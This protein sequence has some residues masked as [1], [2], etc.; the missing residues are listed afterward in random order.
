MGGG[1]KCQ[2]G[3]ILIL[4]SCQDTVLEN[5]VDPP[6][7]GVQL[8]GVE[9]GNVQTHI[10]VQNNKHVQQDQ[11]NV[12]NKSTIQNEVQQTTDV[13]LQNEVQ[14]MTDVQLQNEI[15]QM[16][17]VQLQNE[18]Q[19]ITDVQLQNEVQQM[20]DVQLQNEVQQLNE[21]NLLTNNLEKQQNQKVSEIYS[22]TY[23]EKTYLG[24]PALLGNLFLSIIVN[25]QI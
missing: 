7:D 24:N 13:Q 5:R 16:T 1:V 10:H 6:Q 18:V 11:L 3:F 17:D 2:I 9:M 12:E 22:T 23:F 19:Q 14:Q 4:F 8:Y 25:L 21:S 15:Q 20:T